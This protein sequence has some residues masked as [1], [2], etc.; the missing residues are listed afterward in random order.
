MVVGTQRH[1]RIFLVSVH[2]VDAEG[3]LRDPTD[4]PPAAGVALHH[5]GVTQSSA[6]AGTKVA[7]SCRNHTEQVARAHPNAPLTAR[8]KWYVVLS[9]KRTQWNSAFWRY[10]KHIVISMRTS[11]V[12][13]ARQARAQRRRG[14]QERAGQP[15]VRCAHLR[16]R[17]L[18]PLGSFSG[19]TGVVAG[20]AAFASPLAR[21]LPAGLDH[22]VCNRQSNVCVLHVS[23][24]G[25]SAGALSAT[26][27]VRHAL[28]HL[29]PRP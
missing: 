29:G 27:R 23:G 12:E 1:V 26:A 28:R 13:V 8:Y 7:R 5:Q 17:D 16:A 11:G 6:R 14:A 24:F 19:R 20:A 18:R 9:T 10:E 21:S 22:H 2:H 4:S 3:C 15:R 25:C